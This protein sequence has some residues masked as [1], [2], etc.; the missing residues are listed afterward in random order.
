MATVSIENYIKTIYQSRDSF[1]KISTSE[2]ADKL[3]VSNA[4]V[5]DMAKKLS[6]SGL[7][8]YKKYEGIELTEKGLKLA[9]QVIRRHRLWELFLTRVLG[10]SWSEVHQ[11]AERLEHHSSDSL[12]N[13]IEEYLE[14]PTVDPHGDPIPDREGNMP[15]LPEFTKLI[16]CRAGQMYKVIRVHD[17]DTELMNYLSRIGVTLNKKIKV[18]QKLSFDNSVII[19]VDG[20]EHILSEKIS[21]HIFVVEL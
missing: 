21:E 4:A 16:E 5:S 15:K 19:R 18:T 2:M 13:K 12:V 8:S 20:S 17:K 11:E 6:S 1:D 7:I 9:M 10:L 3:D 14:Y